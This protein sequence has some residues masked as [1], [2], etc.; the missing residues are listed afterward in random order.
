MA[1]L[2]QALKVGQTTRNVTGQP[3][4]LVAQYMPAAK[5]YDPKRCAYSR[6]VLAVL[7]DAYRTGARTGVLEA[8]VALW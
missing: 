8:L 6:R 4:F 5:H 3:V 7:D 2:W 1:V